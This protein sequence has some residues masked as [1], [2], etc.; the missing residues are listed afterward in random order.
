[1][2]FFRMATTAQRQQVFKNMI[3]LF[4]RT[5]RSI[6]V[7]MVNVQVFFASTMLA[8]VLV[9][10]QGSISI[11]AKV[12]IVFGLFGVLLKP[13]FVASKPVIY[14]FSLVRL[15]ASWATF[16]RPGLVFK[17][18]AAGAAHQN[19]ADWKQSLLPAHSR[20]GGLVLLCAVLWHA[21]CAYFLMTARRFVRCAALG[22]QSLGKS[23]TSL[24]V[25]L[26][27]ARLAPFHVGGRF[28]SGCLTVWADQHA[29]SAHP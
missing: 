28:G 9:A 19:C 10:A 11:A 8:C 26:E 13:L 14:A 24:T 25:G 5:C 12:V 20:Q 1:M 27:S 2:M 3:S 22:T 15:L 4:F 21:G 6:A 29:V 17:V 16:L 7:N 18:I 23:R